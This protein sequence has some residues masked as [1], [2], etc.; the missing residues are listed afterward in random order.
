MPPSRRMRWLNVFVLNGSGGNARFITNGGGAV[1]IS[2]LTSGGTT[3]GSI[4]G[5]GSY[6]LGSKSLTVGS[7]NLSTEVSGV[8]QDGGSSGGIGGS[9]VKVGSGTLTLSGANTYSGGTTI[10]GGTLRLANN[11]ALG[12]GALTTTGSVVDYANGVTIANPIVVNSNTTQLSVTAGSATQ[13]G[14]ISELNGP[15]PLEKIGA[16]TLV[17]SAANT[18]SGP[19]TVSAGTLLVTGSIANSAITVNNGGLLTGTGT[20][21]ATTILSG[22]TFAPGPIGTPGAMTVQGSLAFQSGALYLVQVN[23]S[24]ASSANT[25]AGGSAAL[26]GTVQAAFASGSYVS[27]TYTILSAA[28]GLGGTTFNAL[29]TS[30]LPG[31]FTANLSYTAS[32]V[33]LNLIANL[34]GPSAL[35]T[36]GLSTNQRNVANS[37]N[38]FFN[39]GGALPPGFVSVF[40]LDRRAISAMRLSQLSGEAATGGQQVAFQMTNQFLGPAVSIDITRFSARF[41]V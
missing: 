35:G 27:R 12:T 40:G 30:N 33:I 24:N 14:V 20:V 13:A 18:Y 8:I 41:G 23:P 25:L 17:L 4:E 34:G 31:G 32:D 38:T 21:G 28:G 36:T 15:R 26:A 6:R 5:G 19:T 3:A 22:G 29:T 39:N 37:L 2:G 9:L 10:A 7:N 1:D 16:G 11:Q